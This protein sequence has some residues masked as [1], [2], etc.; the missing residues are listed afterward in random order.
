MGNLWK[1]DTCGCEIEVQPEAWGDA[2]DA[3]NLQVTFKVKCDEHATLALGD[4]ALFNRIYRNEN[5]VKNKAVNI[6]LT[7]NPEVNAN[8]VDFTFDKDR[9]LTLTVNKVGQVKGDFSALAG[10]TVKG[11]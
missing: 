2:S 7:E 9:K 4:K 6:I 5:M 3:D 11:A 10:V 1:P 8:D